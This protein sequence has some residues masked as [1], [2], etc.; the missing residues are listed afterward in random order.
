MKGVN[1]TDNYLQFL[2]LLMSWFSFS[3]HPRYRPEQA[4]VFKDKDLKNTLNTTCSAPSSRQK[5]A[6]EH[7]EAFSWE[8]KHMFPLKGGGDQKQR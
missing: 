6:G 3:R 1:P 4:A 8:E 2:Q 7:C 5:L